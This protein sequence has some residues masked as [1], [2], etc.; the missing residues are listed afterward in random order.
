MHKVIIIGS[1]P[2]AYTAA[3]YTA[4]ANHKPVLLMPSVTYNIRNYEKI[5]GLPGMTKDKFGC[6]MRAQLERFGVEMRVVESV[7]VVTGNGVDDEGKVD[8]DG[9]DAYGVDE[10]E[11]EQRINDKVLRVN[12]EKCLALIIDHDIGVNMHSVFT[13]GGDE[14]IIAI[15]SGCMA[16]IKCNEYIEGNWKE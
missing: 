11:N 1:S 10:V 16:A 13:C 7:E 9:V 15:G 2:A 5:A 6:L 4:T 14:A 3:L 12:G 8:E